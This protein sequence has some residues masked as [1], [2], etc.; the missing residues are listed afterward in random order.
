MIQN[1]DRTGAMKR[2]I[3]LG[4]PEGLRDFYM[5]TTINPATRLSPRAIEDFN[6]YA[7]PEERE[8]FRFLRQLQRPAPVQ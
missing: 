2:M 5:R 4:I 8:R 1:G 3:E 7:T 6:L